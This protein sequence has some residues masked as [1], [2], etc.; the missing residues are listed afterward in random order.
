MYLRL[1]GKSLNVSTIHK[2]QMSLYQI[3]KLF[4]IQFTLKVQHVRWKK[5]QYR[6]IAIPFEKLFCSFSFFSFINKVVR[7]YTNTYK[8]QYGDKA[9]RM[10]YDAQE[11]KIKARLSYPF[12]DTALYKSY[13]I[14]CFYT[15]GNFSINQA[16]IFTSQTLMLSLVFSSDIT[17]EIK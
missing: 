5:Y 14:Q 17:D 16:H 2:S 15:W 12:V 7:L 4:I 3:N 9:I 8:K 13:A 6:Y 11:K 10:M 1:N